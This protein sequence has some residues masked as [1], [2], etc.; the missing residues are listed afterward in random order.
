MIEEAIDFIRDLSTRYARP[1]VYSSFGKDSMVMLDLVERAGLR[2]PI[3]FHR[4][5]FFPLKYEFAD[6]IISARH[7]EVHDYAPIGMQVAKRAGVIEIVNRHQSG[8][9]CDWTPIGIRAP[10]PGLPYLCGYQD[11]YNKPLAPFDF[12]WDLA[13]V[14]QKSS[15][16][17]PILGGVPLKTQLH[18]RAD[19]GATIAFP[20]RD[21]T[22]ADVW[23]YT[24]A[25][26]L[27]I[28]EK[29][30]NRSEGWKEF[31]DITFNPDYF[32]ACTA[33][34]DRDQPERVWCP[35]VERMIW[36][37]SETIWASSPPTI[38]YIGVPAESGAAVRA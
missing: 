33:C 23:E 14:G 16:V 19:G 17:D 20:L 13:F 6:Q 10:E 12:P 22:D 35:K 27:P 28:N 18:E 9:A 36:N 32:H 30:Y 5:A 15:D 11:L 38:E 29:R 4:E 37:A 34:I 25:H 7:Y 3:L 8:A 26:S 24:L 2:P 21:F 1:V 31:A